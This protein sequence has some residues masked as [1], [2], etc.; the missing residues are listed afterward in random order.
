MTRDNKPIIQTIRLDPR[1][2]ASLLEDIRSGEHK[3]G[4][5]DKRE[6]DRVWL[7]Q[8]ILVS[9]QGKHSNADQYEA[10]ARNISPS[11][12][13]LVHGVYVY[14]ETPCTITIH[15]RTGEQ[16]CLS[17]T[18]TRCRHITGMLHEIGAKFDSEIEIEEFVES[19][20]VVATGPQATGDLSKCVGTILIVDDNLADQRLI[21][22]LLSKSSLEFLLAETAEEAL[23]F[24][25]DFP[26]VIICDINLP[27]MSGFEL[28]PKMRNAGYAGPVI[29]ETGEEDS[30]LKEKA[31][32]IGAMDLIVKPCPPTDL[33]TAVAKALALV[34]S[35]PLH[36]SAP[37]VSTADMNEMPVELIQDYIEDLSGI[38]D[39]IEGVID[40]IDKKVL[41]DRA[42]NVKSSALGYGFA[43]LMHAAST[44]VKVIDQDAD[45]SKVKDA[46][47]VLLSTCRRAT[48]P[49]ASKAA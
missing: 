35:S 24:L 46:A 32:Q 47:R 27:D 42:I 11:G 22:H 28:V 26:T 13:S 8:R 14:P 44:L 4:A 33:R 36:G 29:M 45:E 40:S 30:E 37:I 38:A 48:A 23:G 34:D 39:D 43:P 17:G 2:L 1:K 15:T 12:I 7:N 3:A 41:R 18:V 16:Q 20:A 31:M 10:Y 6:A 21:Q 5:D 19:A 49:P 25:V 9:F